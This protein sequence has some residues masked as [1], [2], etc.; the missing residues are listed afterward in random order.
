MSIHSSSKSTPNT[1]KFKL[2]FLLRNEE[3][4]KKFDRNIYGRISPQ[5]CLIMLTR[6]INLTTH[7]FFD[8]FRRFLKIG[9]RTKNSAIS[10]MSIPLNFKVII[11]II[12]KL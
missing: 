7:M 6:Y 8:V 9:F 12:I 10:F 5:K 1:P 11:Y 4:L 2:K 3:K